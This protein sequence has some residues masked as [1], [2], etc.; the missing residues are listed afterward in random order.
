ME[1]KCGIQGDPNFE[2]DTA[3]HGD[4]ASA[5]MDVQIRTQTLPVKRDRVGLSHIPSPSLASCRQ[6]ALLI[7]VLRRIMCLGGVKRSGREGG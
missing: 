1:L 3:E 2:S 5:Y 7:F 4:P 6:H